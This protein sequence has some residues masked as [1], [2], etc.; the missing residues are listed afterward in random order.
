MMDI[1]SN[2]LILDTQSYFLCHQAHNIST[3]C[4]SNLIH[5][6]VG[7]TVKLPNLMGASISMIICTGRKAISI[8]IMPYEATL[9]VFGRININTKRPSKNPAIYLLQQG[10]V[11]R[12]E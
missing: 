12:L 9:R 3:G 8:S 10:K 5:A 11:S 1:K 6:I 4:R 7:V 2:Y